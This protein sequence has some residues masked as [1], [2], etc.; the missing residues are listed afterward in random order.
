ML[1][2]TNITAPAGFSFSVLPFGFAFSY[3][4][5]QF[6]P[7]PPIEA[8]RSQGFV[9]APSPKISEFFSKYLIL[10]AIVVICLGRAI[11]R[12]SEIVSRHR[13]VDAAH[14]AYTSSTNHNAAA[15]TSSLSTS[16]ENEAD[17]TSATP[18]TTAADG[19]ASGRAVDEEQR[20]METLASGGLVEET[21]QYTINDH[22]P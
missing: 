16:T 19:P 11:R 18:D 8:A 2:Y 17:S 15:S 4:S 3:S 13:V 7:V 21:P 1:S 9:V 22:S 12:L 5:V 14:D 6:P 10:G 20:H